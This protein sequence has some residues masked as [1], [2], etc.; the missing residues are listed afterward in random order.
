MA[1]KAWSV[2]VEGTKAEIL[3]KVDSL[4]MP[5]NMKAA[6]KAMLDNH[7]HE[8]PIA[9]RVV[10][11][12]RG[13]SPSTLADLHEA[14]LMIKAVPEGQRS[15]YIANKCV[16]AVAQTIGRFVLACSGDPDHYVPSHLSVDQTFVS[17]EPT[18]GLA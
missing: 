2:R 8:A 11:V 5:D 4:V 13:F 15:D 9:Q 14:A 18:V 7:D 10:R 6:A 1:T 3:A 12:P 16:D 17:V